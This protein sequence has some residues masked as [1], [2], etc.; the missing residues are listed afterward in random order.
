[1]PPIGPTSRRHRL[2]KID[3]RTGPGRYVRQVTRELIQHCGGPDRISV[4]QRL[5]CERTAIDLL[6]LKLIDADLADGIASDHVLRV[7]HA[8]RNTVR[9]ALRDL[10]LSAAAQPAP[11]LA[12]LVADMSRK[13]AAA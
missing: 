9:L 4:A 11:S 5:L 7:A 8:L 13:G 1:M 3:G 2:R 12:E 6:R 10:G